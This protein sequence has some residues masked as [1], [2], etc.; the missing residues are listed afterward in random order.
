VRRLARRYSLIAVHNRS[1]WLLRDAAGHLITGIA[2][3]PSDRRWLVIA[4]RTIRI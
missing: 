3:S 4:D 1:H 2:R